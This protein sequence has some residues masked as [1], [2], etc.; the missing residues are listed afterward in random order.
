[1]KIFVVCCVSERTAKNMKNLICIM[2]I[3][4][5][6][7]VNSTVVNENEKIEI[8]TAIESQTV[9]Q[10]TVEKVTEKAEPEIQEKI[11][12]P[13]SKTVE[14]PKSVNTS[15]SET[16]TPHTSETQD[17]MVY[18]E[19]FGYVE[20]QSETVTTVVTSDG[21]INKMVGIME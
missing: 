18:V 5:A 19:G 15:V 10:I 6:A 16:P 12:V 21:D 1:M 3:V 14:T 17:K 4:L 13:K 11:V 9:P 2:L 7:T 8:S 20:V